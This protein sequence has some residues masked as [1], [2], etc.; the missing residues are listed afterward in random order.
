MLYILPEKG[1]DN[2]KAVWGSQLEFIL[3]I[4]GCAVCLVGERGRQ[5]EGGMGTPARVHSDHRG[6]CCMSC[7]HIKDSKERLFIMT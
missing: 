4:E 6:L 7:R 1:G 5:H 2:T 3:T